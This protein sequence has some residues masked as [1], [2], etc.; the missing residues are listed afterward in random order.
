MK[1]Q[2]TAMG[3]LSRAAD[4]LIADGDWHSF[5]ESPDIRYRVHGRILQRVR[6]EAGEAEELLSLFD[7]IPPLE[8]GLIREGFR[9]AVCLRIEDDRYVICEQF[10]RF[11]KSWEALAGAAKRFGIEMGYPGGNQL[12]FRVPFPEWG[13]ETLTDSLLRVKAFTA[14][15]SQLAEDE[16]FEI[17]HSENEIHGLLISALDVLREDIVNRKKNRRARGKEIED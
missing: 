15:A 8:P 10:I 2:Q 11:F 6:L 5:E 17:P 9:D 7:G 14:V 4:M 13:A 3:R 1:Y 16:K 12:E